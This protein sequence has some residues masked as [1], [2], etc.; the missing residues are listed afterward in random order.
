MPPGNELSIEAILRV[1]GPCLSTRLCE[2]L[3]VRGL[4]ADAARQ[5]IS[6]AK[7]DNIC[8]LPGLIFPRGVRFIYLESTANSDIFWEALIRDVGKAS[9]S[10]A[11]AIGGLRA[12]GGIVPLSQFNVVS[13]APL[14]QKGQISSET[15]LARL[16]AV[17][18][19]EVY[20]VDGIGPCVALAASG[21]FRRL[22]D[23]VLKARLLTE[24]ILLLAVKDWARKLGFAS[25]GKVAIRDDR[26][27]PPRVGTF[28]WDLTGPSYLSPLIRR[29]ADGTPKPGF[30]VCD[31]TIDEEVEESGAA[32]FVRKCHSMAM[33]HRIPPIL[34]IFIAGR[35]S[36]E[37]LNLGR[38]SGVVMATPN[39]LFGR[40]IAIGLAALMQTLT[41]AAAVAVK[42]PE[43][44]GE[45][46]DKLGQIEGAAGNL[47]GALFEILVG[48]C[49]VKLEDGSIDIG[50]K[51]IDSMTQERAEIDV[52]RVKEYREAWVYECKAHQPSQIVSK[53]MVEEWF[54]TRVPVI[55][56]VLGSEARFHDCKF[57]FEY[58]TCGSFDDEALEFLT[59]IK[60]RTKKYEI[61][62]KDGKAV[63]EYVSKVKPKAVLETFDQHFFDHPIARF[64]KKHNA[65]DELTESINWVLQG[66]DLGLSDD[67]AFDAADDIFDLDEVADLEKSTSPSTKLR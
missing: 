61:G 26:S 21:H 36:K 23:E 58:W 7:G 44:V 13:G 6:R 55:F 30:L 43:I 46:F 10:Y 34:P 64:V 28:A 8:R 19:M 41:K 54:T 32:A 47:R 15:V 52:F 3:E 33:L 27:E 20:D 35:F 53:E 17:R 9:P 25:F 29:G 1:E 59:K 16:V 12:R 31:I 5:R 50:R 14:K 65:N 66:G 67:I 37:A 51:V 11:A 63:R 24:K 57:H 49:V 18:L 39:S 40:D 45:L 2:I 62:W 4:S 60:E 42:R 48:H 38:S 22:P 56:R